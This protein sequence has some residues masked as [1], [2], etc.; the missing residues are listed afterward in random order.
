MRFE[1]IY[2]SQFLV[3]RLDYA[4]V[5]THIKDDG[6]II[7]LDL[8]TGQKV[9]VLL[10]ERVMNVSDIQHYYIENTARGIH[11]L[12]MVWADVFLPDDGDMYVLMVMIQDI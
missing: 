2:A 3:N 4:R 8:T 6:D 1:T 11:T 12:M 9:M 5:V 10:I 7:Q